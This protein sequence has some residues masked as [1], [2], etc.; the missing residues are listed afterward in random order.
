MTFVIP[1]IVCSIVKFIQEL[2][3]TELK[4]G[5]VVKLRQNTAKLLSIGECDSIYVRKDYVDLLEQWKELKQDKGFIL[6]GSPGIGKSTFGLLVFCYEISIGHPVIYHREGKGFQYFDGS[7]LIYFREMDAP[8]Q[9][10]L[11][12]KCSMIYDSKIGYKGSKFL[13]TLV[14]HSPSADR[15][16]S[17][18]VLKRDIIL[19]P[20]SREEV[21]HMYGKE[22]LK[23]PFSDVA[24]KFHFA[25]GSLRMLELEEPK[26]EISQAIKVVTGASLENVGK[27]CKAMFTQNVQLCHRVFH[28]FPCAAFD[29]DASGY[30][31]R[32]AS[33]YVRKHVVRAWAENYSNALLQLSNHV[34][35]HGSLR[36]EIF[37]SRMQDM[38]GTSGKVAFHTRRLEGKQVE[39]EEIELELEASLTFDSAAEL[40]KLKVSIRSL[41]IS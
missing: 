15:R 36:G 33:D 19:A 34:D 7:K 35:I 13:K 20:L 10:H 12:G 5:D 2:K 11:M 8:T 3:L 22:E 26:R 4:T 24:K 41:C 9:N 18:K 1:S 40:R 31:V 29:R 28:I 39:D 16:C 17:F 38:M 32:F 30:T 37:E 25:G 23:L 27:Y 6:W 14:I 21:V